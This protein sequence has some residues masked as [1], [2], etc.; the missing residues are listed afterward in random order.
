MR[1]KKL[2]NFS[3]LSYRNPPFFSISAMSRERLKVRK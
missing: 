1:D 3:H 2:S